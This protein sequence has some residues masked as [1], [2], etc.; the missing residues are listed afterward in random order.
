[1][2]FSPIRRCCTAAI[3]AGSVTCLLASP[4]SQ[5]AEDPIVKSLQDFDR[6]HDEALDLGE[7]DEG[8]RR[9][10]GLPPGAE[11]PDLARQRSLWRQVFGAGPTYKI[12]Q[13]AVN[14]YYNEKIFGS[15]KAEPK[16]VDTTHLWIPVD[17]HPFKIRR[18]LSDLTEAKMEAAKGAEIS[19]SN[20]FN[21]HSEQW[22][23]HGIVGYDWHKKKN[24]HL[25]ETPE[26]KRIDL[27]PNRDRGL[28]DYW[29]IPS[30]QWDKV[31][32]SKSSKAEV[33][34]LI[35]RLTTGFKTVTKDAKHSLLD[36][37]RVDLSAG[38]ATDSGIDKGVASGEV[39]LK[40]FMYESPG[41]GVGV[42]G[43]FHRVGIF[44]L[45]PELVFHAEAGTVVDDGGLPELV[46]QKDFF[47]I[48]ARVGLAVRFEQESGRYR[49]FRGLL[50]HTGLQ[51]YADVTD[52]GPDVDLFTASADWAIDEEGHYT[53]TA[54]YRN[55]RAPLVLERDNRLTVGLGV[56]F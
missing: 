29:I 53:L 11:S 23:F 12:Q 30:V 27:D 46:N 45:R 32:T 14:P 10:L 8:L 6:N 19:Y 52:A 17:E 2:K 1:M 56:K 31:D 13:L 4:L 24:V 40:P 54:V 26:G 22:A 16:K 20:D 35:L 44:R 21:S 47:R 55:G 50:L 28:V 39:D 18:T 42:N 51:Y 9:Q 36:G 33:D 48:G 49:C 7:V 5:A 15:G 41:R 38:Y 34:T 43:A 37:W 3:L 25:G